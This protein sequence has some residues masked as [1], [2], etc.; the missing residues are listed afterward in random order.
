[1]FHVKHEGWPL[2][3]IGVKLDANQLSQLETFEALLEERALPQGMVGAKDLPRLRSRHLLDSLRGAAAVQPEDRSALDMGSGAGLPG[4]VVAIACPALSVTLVEV[5][6][7]KAAFLELAR[8]RLQV[9][10]A[11]VHHGRVEDLATIVDLCLARAFAPARK[12]WQVAEPLLAPGGRLLY[13]AGDS[14]ETSDIPLGVKAVVSPGAA[15][16]RSG[17]LVMMCRQ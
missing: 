13:W 1:V 11:S 10:N 7:R 17:P 6:S 12:S 9:T 16:A 5:R 3:D 4:L 15:L 2:E 8:D 14:F